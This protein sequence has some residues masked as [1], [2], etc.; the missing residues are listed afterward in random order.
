MID[1]ILMLPLGEDRHLAIF[2]DDPS[3]NDVDSL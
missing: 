3:T 2:L 1:I